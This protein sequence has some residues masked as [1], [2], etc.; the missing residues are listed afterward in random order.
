MDINESLVQSLTEQKEKLEQ[1]VKDLT[2]DFNRETYMA[3]GFLALIIE[4]GN[5]DLIKRAGEIEIEAF[6]ASKE[7]LQSNQ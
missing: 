6:K 5:A 2:Q 3:S 7:V 4:T 1:Q